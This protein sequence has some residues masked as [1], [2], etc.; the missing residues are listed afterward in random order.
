MINTP[1]DEDLTNF[2]VKDKKIDTEID[3]QDV[4]IDLKQPES[5]N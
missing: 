5:F 3:Q 2:V 1:P 4:I